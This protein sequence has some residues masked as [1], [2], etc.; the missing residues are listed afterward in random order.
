MPA[1]KDSVITVPW[2]WACDGSTEIS[3]A[4]IIVMFQLFCCLHDSPAKLIC[5]ESFGPTKYGLSQS[6]CAPHLSQPSLAKPLC[7]TA[8][9]DA[10]MLVSFYNPRVECLC[11]L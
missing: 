6:G 2:P 8:V 1:A 9:C 11:R 4:Y 5:A 3:L 7:A 10:L